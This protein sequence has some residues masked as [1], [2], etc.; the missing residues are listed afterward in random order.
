MNASQSPLTEEEFN[1]ERRAENRAKYLHGS[2]AQSHE[3]PPLQVFVRI[4]EPAVFAC[5]A[6]GGGYNS[7]HVMAEQLP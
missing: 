7:A 6:R 4:V 3:P 1:H 2:P 5:L